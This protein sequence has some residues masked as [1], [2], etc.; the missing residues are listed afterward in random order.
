MKKTCLALTA[1][2]LVATIVTAQNTP[3]SQMEKL[4]R[5]VIVV[6]A[7]GTGNFISWRLFGTDDENTTFDILRNGIPIVT[8]Q[9]KTNY[10]D[11]GTA[12]TALYQIVTKENGVPVDT[13]KAVT[14]WGKAYLTIPLDQPAT[15][16]QGGTYAPNDCSVGDVDGDGEYEIFLKWDPSTAKDN[17]QDGITDNVY[18][19][20]YKL[21]G[22]RLW[23]I[24]LG[25]NIRAGAH[26]TQFMVYDFDGDGKAEMMC[27]T[28]PGSKDGLGTYVNQAAT[29][30][31]IKAANNAKDWAAAGGGRINGG[32]EYL[33][34]FEGLTG[35]AIH[36][37][38]TLPA[39]PRWS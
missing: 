9:S 16:A 12:S 31:T 32:Q 11:A 6:P 26:Y 15:G 22:T 21:N 24:D 13:S 17:S 14:S 30:A 3:A 33:T 4:D 36:M 39:T 10:K 19:D 23:R 25:R 8:N 37:P 2:L 1:C 28:A 5:G 20:C 7:V 34:V 27:K 38:T 35:K 18:I 29:N